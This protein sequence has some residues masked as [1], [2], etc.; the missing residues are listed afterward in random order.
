M[1]LLFIHLLTL[2]YSWCCTR[3]S[4]RSG[5]FTLIGNSILICSRLLVTW[6][7]AP[8][9][10]SATQLGLGGNIPA[11]D[12]DSRSSLRRIKHFCKISCF[13]WWRLKEP[14]NTWE[15]LH[16]FGK[17]G[18]ENIYSKIHISE[19]LQNILIAGQRKNKK[20]EDFWEVVKR[21]SKCKMVMK[22]KINLQR[23]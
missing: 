21:I 23:T 22:M 14:V 17:R 13:I 8:G 3:E 12:L 9:D 11:E 7:A 10:H 5:D 19:P 15:D 2:P 18:L 1:W 4:D 20:E 16:L 6:S